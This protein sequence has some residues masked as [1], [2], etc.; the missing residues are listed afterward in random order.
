MILLS[1]Y[2]HRVRCWLSAGNRLNAKQLNI[3]GD[4]TMTKDFMKRFL[5]RAAFFTITASMLL[6][7]APLEAGAA[8]PPPEPLSCSISP[9]DGSTVAGVPI[10]FVGDTQGGRNVRI[11]SWDFS[12]GAGVPATSVVSAW[13]FIWAALQPCSGCG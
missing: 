8:K 6:A 3:R 5:Q 7:L 2:H 11:Y 9:A 13:Q 4:M 10:T 1:G 12:D